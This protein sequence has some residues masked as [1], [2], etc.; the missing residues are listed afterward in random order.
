[1]IA[2]AFKKFPHDDERG[3]KYIRELPAYTVPM[4]FT[5]SYINIFIRELPI[6]NCRIE[7]KANARESVKM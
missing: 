7:I 5:S 4:N 6:I 1:M 3:D 2:S